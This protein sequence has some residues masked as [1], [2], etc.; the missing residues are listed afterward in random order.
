ML[1]N[2]LSKLDTCTKNPTST[3]IPLLQEEIR[4]VETLCMSESDKCVE[5][6]H[7][8]STDRGGMRY[9]RVELY[10]FL[11]M[12]GI[13]VQRLINFP[14]FQKH[15]KNIFQVRCYNVMYTHAYIMACSHR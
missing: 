2:D 12:F 4:F 14:I 8:P 13:S 5:K 10:P 7:L 3:K 6:S 11:R 9:P 15:G 1:S